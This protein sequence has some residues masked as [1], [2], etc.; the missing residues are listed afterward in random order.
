MFVSA[1]MIR[2]WICHP[3][4]INPLRLQNRLKNGNRMS[5]QHFGYAMALQSKGYFFSTRSFN[6]HWKLKGVIS[7][8]PVTLSRLGK[9]VV[10]SKQ[11]MDQ[12]IRCQIGKMK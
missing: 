2:L 7:K 11:N 10:R 5:T 6:D 8:Q 12:M 9:V 1:M 3:Y 4:P